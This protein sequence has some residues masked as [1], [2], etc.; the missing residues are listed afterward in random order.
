[1]RRTVRPVSAELE[2]WVAIAHDLADLADELT[3]PAFDQAAFDVERKS[4]GTAVTEIDLA[5]E[6]RL[7][8]EIARQLPDH[9]FLG[10][11]DGLEGAADAPRWII[12]PIDGT[13]NFVKGNPVWATLIACQVDGEEILGIASAP[14]LG[15]RWDGVRGGPARRDGR[16]IR[17]SGVDSL[18]D[19]EVSLGGLSYFHR[20]GRG[21]LV[22]ALAERTGRQRG[23]GDF[24]QHCLVAS[25]STDLALE[26]EVKLWDLAAV[27]CIVEA[28]GGRFTS[29]DGV[30]T[31][32]GGDAL[33]T[34]GRLHEAALELIREHHADRD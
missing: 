22:T 6:R 8:A 2:R 11:E 23:Y 26:A 31:A 28:A 18:G 10:E 19:A 9:A 7:R 33:S 17:V 20:H 3:G 24:W 12:D 1:V 32:D 34:N 15:S 5:V 14:A 13:T 25:G 16:P 27:K 29:L 30:V 21:D 4:D